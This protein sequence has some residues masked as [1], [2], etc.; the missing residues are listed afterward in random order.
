M[1][2]ASDGLLLLLAGGDLALGSAVH[3]LAAALDFLL[4][5]T[6]DLAFLLEFGL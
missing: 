6:G 4:G 2:H 1:K 5:L 3:L